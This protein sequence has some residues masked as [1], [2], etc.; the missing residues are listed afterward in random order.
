VRESSAVDRHPHP[1]GELGRLF[2]FLFYI[3]EE[4]CF[5]YPRMFYIPEEE[6]SGEGEEI[7]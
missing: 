3:P 5:T 6:N 1:S 4:E 2:Y 7:Q